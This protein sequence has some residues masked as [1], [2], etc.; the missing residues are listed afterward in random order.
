MRN[1]TEIDDVRT[2]NTRILLSAELIKLA[3]SD[4]EACEILLKHELYPQAIFMA[5]QSLEKA[6]K[7]ILLKLDLADEKI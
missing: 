4:L 6:I 5:Q 7:A 2:D 3:S 1:N